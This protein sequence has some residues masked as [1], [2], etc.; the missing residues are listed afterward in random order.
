MM[1][2]EVL[3]ALPMKSPLLV[4]AWNSFFPAPPM[5]PWM[6]NVDN[7]SWKYN[8]EASTSTSFKSLRLMPMSAPL[9]ENDDM[10]NVLVESATPVSSGKE[11]VVYDQGFAVQQILNSFRTG[12]QTDDLAPVDS[13]MQEDESFIIDMEIDEEAS[14]S[15]NNVWVN[16][17]TPLTTRKKRKG[18]AKTPMV[19]DA[20]RK[21][22]RF[23]NNAEQTFYQLDREPRR[24]PGA[25]KR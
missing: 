5:E 13:T 25:E 1:A 23:N 8:N 19:D 10:N 18:R 2:T 16:D 15:Q 22:S 9:L 14:H 21:S 7:P 11:L 12:G 6:L 3:R 20:M 24:K 4:T 17:V